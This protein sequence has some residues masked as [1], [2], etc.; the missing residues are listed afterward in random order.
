MFW[1]VIF[2]LQIHDLTKEEFISIID[3]IIEKRLAKVLEKPKPEYLTVKEAC[4]FARVC[5]STLR[6]YIKEFNMGTKMIKGKI[7][8]HRETFEKKW[9]I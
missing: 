6:N 1:G 4:T 5:D 2:T 3:E 9:K 7:I 8:I